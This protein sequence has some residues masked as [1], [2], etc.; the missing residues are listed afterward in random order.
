MDS[1]INVIAVIP[2]RGGSK[3]IPRKNLRPLAG[4]PLIWYAIQACTSVRPEIRVVVST[5]DDEIA[6]FS[7]RFGAK[8]L[9]RPPGLSGDEVTLDP[10]IVGAV[11]QA[12]EQYSERYDL[13]LTVQP[14]SPLV[15]PSDLERAI[16][17][18]EDANVDTV[19]SVVDDKHLCWTMRDGVPVPIYSKRV[20]RQQLMPNFRETGAIIACRRNQ[21]ERGTRIGGRVALHEVPHERSFDIDTPVDFYLCESILARKRIV[22]VVVG[23]AA[24]GLGHAFRSVTLAHEMVR[25][26]VS[27]ICPETSD[28]AI[29]YIRRHNY[30][31]EVCARENLLDTVLAQRPDMV[32]NDIL[33][34]DA[35]Y[36]SALKSSSVRVV[37]FEDLGDGCEHADLVVNALYPHPLQSNHT[38]VGAAYFCLRD[39]FLHLPATAHG[40]SLDR[41]LVTFGGV[42]EGDL[43]ARVLRLLVPLCIDRRIAIDVVT[44]PGYAH[45]AGLD[46]LVRQLGYP[47]LDVVPAT[48]RISDYMVRAG[49][50]VTSGGRTVL[51]L[52][53]LRVPTVVICQNRKEMTHTFASDE[54]GIL[55]LGYRGEVGDARIASA[56]GQVLG[57][58]H[59][60]ATMR[61]RMARHDFTQG[62]RRVIERMEALMKVQR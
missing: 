35:A 40:N 44:G 50:A 42:D 60:R 47:L 2:A 27:F 33:D 16:A 55:S 62:K 5:D 52:A 22:F 20:N 57:N 4:K 41:V 25:H 49:M 45:R 39:E 36:V 26:A 29:E 9:R 17:R 38:L 23:H 32:V 7:E 59:I 56:L 28:L 53:A 11:R 6:L 21:L 24:V 31:V 48:Q 14:T 1:S 15:L 10:V 18:F 19:L 3:G 43:T 13:V 51:E 30:P 54:N 58:A 34:T 8:V 61:E 12:E 37:D 46:S